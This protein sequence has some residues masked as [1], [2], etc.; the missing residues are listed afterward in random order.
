MAV[1]LG[2]EVAAIAWYARQ[3]D[4]DQQR[5]AAILVLFMAAQLFWA[6]FEQNGSS[7]ALF[8]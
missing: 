5:V 3:S 8:A 7:I 4:A 1:L 2:V 6:I